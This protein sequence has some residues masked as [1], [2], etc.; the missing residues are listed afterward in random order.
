MA[1]LSMSDFLCI[2]SL[3]RN[4]DVHFIGDFTLPL[5]GL[6]DQHAFFVIDSII[7]KIC[8]ENLKDVIPD[9]RILIVEANENNKSLDK[10]R[11][12]IETLVDMQV[13]RNEKLVAVGGGIIQDVTAFSAS[14]IYR[15][16]EWAFFPTTLLA[17]ADSCIGSKTS[18][19]LGGK[20]N[21]V[22]NF[23]PPAEIFIDSVFLNTL[24]V[25]D[26]KSGIGEI[27]HYYIYAASPLFDELI[28]DYST[29]LRNRTLLEKH[30][31][32]SLEIKKSLI[33]TDE[34]DRG[35]RNKFNYGHTFGHA[36]ESVTD[37]A[38]KHGQAVTTGMD[39]A[40]YVSMKRGFMRPETFHDLHAR[41][42]INFPEYDWRTID[43][44]RYFDLLTKDKKNVGS[45]IG[46]ILAKKPGMLFKEQIPHDDYFRKMIQTYFSGQ[47]LTAKV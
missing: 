28:A 34:F 15:G 13:R 1:V 42:S 17:Q 12:I 6:V 45:N 2:K 4:Y 3:F 36:I 23:F 46:C 39:L 8:K 18:I 22:G 20:K 16:I 37:Y 10:C 27:L 31:R 33:E 41:L 24:S 38:I 7:W 21:L 11:E 19:N 43:L 40:N 14:I 25:D 30:I 32:E 47:E 44:D 9:G 5:Q 29:A 26:I 35:E